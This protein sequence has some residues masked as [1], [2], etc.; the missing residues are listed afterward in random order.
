MDLSYI[1]FMLCHLKET[2]NKD[3]LEISTRW[4]NFFEM[5]CDLIVYKMPIIFYH[6]LVKN[7]LLIWMLPIKVDFQSYF[8]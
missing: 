1:S 8:N 5:V 3:D 2:K 7:R 6:V 4:F